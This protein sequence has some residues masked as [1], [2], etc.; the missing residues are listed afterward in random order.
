MLPG[1]SLGELKRMLKRMGIEVSEVSDVSEVLI[2]TK[3]S[4]IVIEAPQVLLMDSGKQKIYQV[5]AGRITVKKLGKA[6]QKKISF[7]EEDVEFVVKQTGASR[8]LAIRALEKSGGD[9]A[10]AIILINE[11]KALE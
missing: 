10:Q 3:D 9:L 4:E 2:R 6:E 7:S 11:G 8:E 5:V 1:M